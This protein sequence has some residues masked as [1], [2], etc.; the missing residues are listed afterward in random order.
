MHFKS[1]IFSLLIL[2]TPSL[3]LTVPFQSVQV[4]VGETIVA[5]YAFGTNAIIFCY[6]DQFENIGATGTIT[7]PYNGRTMSGTIPITLVTN[8]NYQGQL[9]DGAGEIT[10]QNAMSTSSTISCQFAF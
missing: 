4:G 10:I 9:A 5:N 7:W 2:S 6:S 8:I 3:A 1:L